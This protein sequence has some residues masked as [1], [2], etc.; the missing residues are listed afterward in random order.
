MLS[1]YPVQC[2]ILLT[3]LHMAEVDRKKHP[4]RKQTVEPIKSV[5]ASNRVDNNFFFIK[6]LLG[7][8]VYLMIKL[9]LDT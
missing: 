9:S 2:L 5:P 3:D 1:Q 6:D 7:I 8:G 4:V